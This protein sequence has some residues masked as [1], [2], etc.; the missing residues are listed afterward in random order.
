MIEIESE[1]FFDINKSKAYATLDVWAESLTVEKISELLGLE[2]SYYRKKLEY[3]FFFPKESHVFVT[4]SPTPKENRWS[5]R[6]EEKP[7]DNV[8]TQID[9]LVSVFKNKVKALN[10]IQKEYNCKIYIGVV[11]YNPQRSLPA[12]YV[13]EEHISF[14]SSIGVGIDFDIYLD[15]NDIVK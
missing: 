10:V 15:E 2:I 5:F 3:P 11:L 6:T 7:T 4:L 13:K 1:N 8:A 9:E 12:I 14:F